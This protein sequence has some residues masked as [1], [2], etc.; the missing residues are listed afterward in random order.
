M[1][2]NKKYEYS[3]TYE[4]RKRVK[5]SVLVSACLILLVLSGLFFTNHQEGKYKDP[6]NNNLIVAAADVISVTPMLEDVAEEDMISAA[7]MIEAVEAKDA[8]V[9][10]AEKAAATPTPTVTPTPTPIGSM[11]GVFVNYKDSKILLKAGSGG[12]TKFYI[13]KDKQKSWDLIAE[14][15]SGQTVSVELAG[16]MKSSE[17]TLY[18]K[19]NKDIAPREVVIPKEETNLD[20]SY[21]LEYGEVYGEV[22]KVVKLVFENVTG[23]L[24]YRKSASESWKDYIAK[25]FKTSDYEDT[26]ITLQFRTKATEEKRAGKIVNVKIP[27]RPSAPSIKVDYA[28][29]QITGMK[30]GVTQYRLGTSADWILFKPTDT[31]AKALSLYEL[32]KVTNNNTE[33]FPATT[34]E[35]RT[36]ATEKKVASSVR[37]IEIKQQPSAPFIADL[38]NF[39]LTIADASKDK[40]YEYVVLQAH[41]TF[42]LTKAKWKKVTSSK[43]ILIK[44]TGN[45]TTIPT[46]KVYVRLA[47][48]TDKETKQVT[49][50]SLYTV[51]PV[52]SVSP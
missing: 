19:G 32:L 7:A 1:D 9:S 15:K 14:S 6:S 3:E 23:V 50:P 29:M 40:P 11:V 8:I 20:I 41:E 13:S 36:I 30:Y 51:K 12:S 39:T 46:D 4:S 43:P 24:E 17:T 38:K 44:K 35:F 21:E 25:D 10:M 42:D 33:R 49:P 45:A 2:N 16:Y 37:V 28:K 27:K 34:I 52:T 5:R 31:K 48:V 22:T 18:F 26:G 47:A